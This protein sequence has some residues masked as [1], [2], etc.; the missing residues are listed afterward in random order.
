MPVSAA[1]GSQ[2]FNCLALFAAVL[3]KH[4]ELQEKGPFH[5]QVRYERT[6][7][8]TCQSCCLFQAVMSLF[9]TLQT[10]RVHIIGRIVTHRNICSAGCPDTG[11]LADPGPASDQ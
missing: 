9:Y 7:P 4:P 8:T 3:A 5:Q 1:D 11:G 6:S 2:T 10:S